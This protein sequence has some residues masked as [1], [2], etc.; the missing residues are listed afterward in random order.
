MQPLSILIVAAALGLANAGV[1]AVAV[2][3][4]RPTTDS[5][6]VYPNIAD[7][8][9]ATSSLVGFLHKYFTAKT[10]RDL[11]TFAG[12]FTP[13]SQDVYF[14]ATVGLTVP[15]SILA[16]ELAV[17]FNAS[18][19]DAKSYPLRIIGDMNSAVVLSVSTP[20][21]FKAES[22]PIS[23]V[24]F[25]DGK[26]A[27]WIDYWDGRLSPLISERAPE[28]KFPKTFGESNITTKPSPVIYKVA[29]KLFNAL[30]AGNSKAASSLFTSDAVLEDRS[31]R[32]RIEG[33]LGIEQ[34][35][36]RSLHGTPYGLGSKMRHVV[37]G[38]QGGAYEWIGS[39]AAG[40]PN[41]ITALELNYQG[42][43]TGFYTVWDSSR[44][45][46][47]TVEALVGFAVAE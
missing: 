23:A 8:S 5:S 44:T 38:V 35:L 34:Y 45:S 7:I 20:G 43:I 12:Y 28:N 42:Q 1:T 41:G 16:A 4:P 2:D 15:Q 13:G 36:N 30:T 37:G 11:D 39:P 10:L 22:R 14:D 46:N 33:Q 27:R 18:T 9:H 31:L 25:K 32:T 19:P 47:H 17:L 40:S 3:E 6:Y 26:A 21:L 24:D 29:T